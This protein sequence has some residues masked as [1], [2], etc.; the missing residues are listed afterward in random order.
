MNVRTAPKVQVIE[1]DAQARNAL[2][3]AIKLLQR[4]MPPVTEDGFDTRPH[5]R[6]A[7]ESLLTAVE[8]GVIRCAACG[9]E[10]TPEDEFGDVAP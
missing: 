2:N 8:R 1:L 10:I 5:A 7:M 4:E 6:T 9:H 3:T